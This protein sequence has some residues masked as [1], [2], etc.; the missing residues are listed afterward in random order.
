MV[1]ELVGLYQTFL[2][3]LAHNPKH[4]QRPKPKNKNKNSLPWLRNTVSITLIQRESA[5]WQW[6]NM[7]F[8]HERESVRRESQRGMREGEEKSLTSE[9]ERERERENK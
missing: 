4:K 5:R 6:Q 7:G 8:D 9:R 3:C 1:A 2:G